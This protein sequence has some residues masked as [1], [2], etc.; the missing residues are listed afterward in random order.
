[1]V[2]YYY[3]LVAPCLH[4]RLLNWTLPTLGPTNNGCLEIKIKMWIYLEVNME[5]LQM[6]KMVIE[7]P[8][9]S[10]TGY[11]GW[12]FAIS[13]HQLTGSAVHLAK[14]PW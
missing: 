13:H 8:S 10:E 1:M 4:L 11:Q 3:E 9:N 6:H 5:A 14:T 12:K 7:V 2:S